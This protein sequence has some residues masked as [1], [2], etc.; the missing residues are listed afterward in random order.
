MFLFKAV[1]DILI[2]IIL[3]RLLIRPVEANFNTLFNLIYRVTDTILKPFKTI[4]KNEFTCVV[5]AVL[6][7]VI[8][9]GLIYFLASRVSLLTGTTTSLLNLFQ[10]LF[11]FYM[12]VWFI[13]IFTGERGNTQII[14]M[15]QR[16]FLPLGALA[17]RLNMSGRSFSFFSF[18]VLFIGYSLISFLLSNIVSLKS[19]G[20][21]FYYGIAEAMVL[22]IEL[23][24]GFF[25][26][27]ILVS[28]ILSWV[29]P[30]PYHPVAQTIYGISEPL[31]IPFR[32]IIPPIAGLDL[33]PFAA[34]LC[35]QIVGGLL[36]QAVFN[37]LKMV[38]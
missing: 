35:F 12:V 29:S 5:L 28:V 10:L 15:L 4:V 3:I 27:V 25:S 38:M 26:L 6:S 18:I 13:V 11:Q 19:L 32:R 8:L 36:R 16:A 31:L 22:I 30:S 34:L 2:V 9:R 23:F 7:L 17:S 24:P 33:S 20:L 21:P 1:I 14:S 37:A